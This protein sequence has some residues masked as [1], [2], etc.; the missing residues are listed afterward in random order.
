MITNSKRKRTEKTT[1]AIAA[2]AASSSAR[3]SGGDSDGDSKGPTKLQ[4]T[5]SDITG[6]PVPQPK[7]QAV[8]LDSPSLAPTAA[9]AAE[10]ME[11]IPAVAEER[12]A[13]AAA[14]VK[15]T[16]AQAMA[17]SLSA[18][19]VVSASAAAAARLERENIAAAA[20]ERL[21][22][23]A[24]SLGIRTEEKTD[25]QKR[26]AEELTLL[27]NARKA[28]MEQYKAAAD[29]MI[30]YESY[31][32]EFR[33]YL[34]RDL[35][36]HLKYCN[37]LMPAFGKWHAYQ[38][39]SILNAHDR[40]ES[41]VKDQIRLSCL[42]ACQHCGQIRGRRGGREHNACYDCGFFT[43]QSYTCDD[44][45][46]RALG[47]DPALLPQQ[48]IQEPVCS[49]CNR[50][51]FRRESYG[52]VTWAEALAT[53][54][55]S[56][57]VKANHHPG[58]GPSPYRLRAYERV[59]VGLCLPCKMQR[60]R[61]LFEGKDAP[62]CPLARKDMGWNWVEYSTDDPAANTAKVERLVTPIQHLLKWQ[63]E[64]LALTIKYYNR[65]LPPLLSLFPVISAGKSCPVAE[66]VAGYIRPDWDCTHEHL[67]VYLNFTKARVQLGHTENW[68]I[69]GQVM[70]DKAMLVTN[71]NSAEEK[72]KREIP[73]VWDVLRHKFVPS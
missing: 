63:G 24:A 8:A 40:L 55:C 36:T 5:I 45:R 17:D 26:T 34:E 15:P 29:E 9:A 53:G 68:P 14:A 52:G 21:N 25:D 22:T 27:T 3:S 6:E 71:P 18:A 51:N 1:A 38:T 31:P 35:L 69:T 16:L 62:L 37:A 23:I 54:Y 43:C 42:C 64:D 30:P 7:P 41:A 56:C 48:E 67:T 57:A 2:A 39:G 28:L 4:K 12:T 44:D 19:D 11:E 49:W 33:K 72:L 50:C 70:R 32:V 47:S 66:I 73:G 60:Q 46:R 10:V 65:L 13:A 59:K 58:A 61:A 20:R